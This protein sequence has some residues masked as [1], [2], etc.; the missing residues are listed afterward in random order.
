[1]KNPIRS[2]FYDALESDPYKADKQ[3]ELNPWWN[4][5][6]RLRMGLYYIFIKDLLDVFPKSQV[7]ILRLEDFS[8]DRTYWLNRIFNF[9]NL[10]T[11]PDLEQNIKTQSIYNSNDEAYKKFGNMLQQTQQTLD[12]FYKPYNIKL[13]QL[14]QN[15]YFKWS[16]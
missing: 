5:V 11:D 7:M 15:S 4:P 1:M 10:K 2:C 6:F 16:R 14:L 3:R 12:D 8:S 9:L 13:S